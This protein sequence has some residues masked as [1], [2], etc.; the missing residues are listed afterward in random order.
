MTNYVD[1]TAPAAQ[2]VELVQVAPAVGEVDL[3][4][5][6]EVDHARALRAFLVHGEIA[7]DTDSD[8]DVGA[9]TSH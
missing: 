2:A 7:D 5:Q 8:V 4:P 9:P 3:R 1:I 6:L